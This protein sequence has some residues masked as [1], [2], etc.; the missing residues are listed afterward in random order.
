[1]KA[2]ILIIGSLLW[3]KIDKRKK[4]RDT[5]LL[6]TEKIPVYA[7]IRYGRLSGNGKTYTMVFSSK[8]KVKNTMGTA[9]IVPLANDTNTISDLIKEAECLSYVEGKNE[10]NRL[11][12]GNSIKWAVIG[13][14]FNP[15]INANVKNKVQNIWTKKLKEADF[16]DF[17]E[18][19]KVIEDPIISKSG[20]ISIDWPTAVNNKAQMQIDE[21]DI[22]I[23]TFT[24][25]TGYK[26]IDE[27]SKIIEN[28][29]RNY[30]YNN[31]KHKIKT[32]EDERILKKLNR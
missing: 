15:N 11:V 6:L 29:S 3:D 25:P 1:M 13:H 31:I 28:D 14:I 9:Y 22:I 16:E 21:F 27:Q 2:G 12:K 19:Y 23:T 26:K 17:L 18:N 24:L 8:I 32:F 10:E 7:P 4:W 5:R 30:F 20:N